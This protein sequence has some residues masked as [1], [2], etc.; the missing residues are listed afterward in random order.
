MADLKPL[1]AN[2]Q[3]SRALFDVLIGEDV[4][5]PLIEASSSGDNITLRSMLSQPQWTKIALEKPHCIY[6]QNRPSHDKNDVRSVSAMKMLNLE[7]AIIK[8]AENGHAAV[9]STL[10]SFA[11]Q[12]GL[13][14][15]SVITRWAVDRV[16]NNGHAAVFKA[17]AFADPTIVN[18]PLLGHGTLPL[19]QAVKRS[20]TEVVAVLLQLGA[21]PIRPDSSIRKAYSYRSSL[22]SLATKAEGTRM[23]ELLLKHGVSVARSGALHLAAE[24]GAL[25]TMHLLMQ[26]GADVDEQ[27]TEDILPKHS[28]SLYASWTPMHFAAF[29]GQVEAMK[30][31]ESNGARSDVND[32]NGRTPAQLLEQRKL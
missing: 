23:T 10:L 5:L 29:G 21:D 27:L 20:Q 11:S 15:S 2:Y 14:P 18:S 9:V 16:I 12:H 32:V 28:G 24:L 30:L 6:F 8:A 31:L 3:S 22:L 7:R 4:A 26:Y 25:D 19:D 1:P 13:E 17:L